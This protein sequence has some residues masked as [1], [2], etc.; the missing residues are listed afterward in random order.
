MM[1]PILVKSLTVDPCNCWPLNV[2]MSVCHILVRLPRLGTEAKPFLDISKKLLVK[3]IRSKKTFNNFP[4]LS[5]FAERGQDP[6]HVRGRGFGQ[7]G[8]GSQ[9][10]S[11]TG[12]GKEKAS[13]KEGRGVGGSS[14]RYTVKILACTSNP[15]R[16]FALTSGKNWKCRTLD[17]YEIGLSV[18]L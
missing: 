17:I 11:R 2:R 4:L 5:F 7:N 18:S 8:R 14:H 13:S 6:N 15:W 12:R 1:A 16:T 10:W 9:A 3:K